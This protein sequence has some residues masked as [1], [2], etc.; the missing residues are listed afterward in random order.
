[1]TI[2]MDEAYSHVWPLYVM[3]KFNSQLVSRV[4]VDNSDVLNIL[5]TSMHKKLGKEKV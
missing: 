5:A 4:L 3:A 1:M 2:P